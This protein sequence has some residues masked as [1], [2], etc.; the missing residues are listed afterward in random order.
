MIYED[1]FNLV[2]VEI[3]TGEYL[4]DATIGFCDKAI[5]DAFHSDYIF[6]MRMTMFVGS[7]MN[8]VNKAGH[9]HAHLDCIELSNGKVEGLIIAEPYYYYKSIGN[10]DPT[11][12]MME[13]L[14]K[15]HGIFQLSAVSLGS[16]RCN[17]ITMYMDF[18]KR[19]TTSHLDVVMVDGWHFQS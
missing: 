7:L 15:N 19:R 18:N 14:F 8:S 1:G 5:L 3:V 6:N 13:T 16:P 12:Y 10:A 2:A 9:G 17:R 11:K 4:P